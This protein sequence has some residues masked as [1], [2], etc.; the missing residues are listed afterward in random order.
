MEGLF[1]NAL[2]SFPRSSEC[3]GAIEMAIGLQEPTACPG[4]R[5]LQTALSHSRDPRCKGR[6][7]A[8][9]SPCDPQPA[10]QV[11][12]RE[13]IVLEA[14]ERLEDPGIALACAAPRQLTVDSCGLVPLTHQ[15]V[16]P[17]RLP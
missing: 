16:Q 10:R 3:E 8:G 6:K 13:K 2:S 14:Q 17:A 11:T 12:G 5:D 1:W 9:N 15:H 7:D 4:M